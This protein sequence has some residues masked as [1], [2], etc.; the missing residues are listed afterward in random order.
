MTSELSQEAPIEQQS[1]KLNIEQ[2]HEQILLHQN[3]ITS[4]K[5]IIIACLITMIIS[6]LLTLCAVVENRNQAKKKQ[7]LAN[8]PVYI[9]HARNLAATGNENALIWLAISGNASKVEFQKLHALVQNNTKNPNVIDALLKTD[10]I[11]K[12]EN[13]EFKGLN[14][15]EIETLK[16]KGIE[17]G[18]SKLIEE[19]YLEDAE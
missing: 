11:L 15:S 7:S 16:A 14:D 6:A 5:K 3:S 2:T 12:K 10:E 17:L 1:N 4:G 18:S 19:K 13:P 8:Q 9:E